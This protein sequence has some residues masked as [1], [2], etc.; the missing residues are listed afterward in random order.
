MNFLHDTLYIDRCELEYRISSVEVLHGSL[1]CAGR[2]EESWA[3]NRLS[4]VIRKRGIGLRRT[5]NLHITPNN[6][7]V[8]RVGSLLFLSQ[9]HGATVLKDYSRL[10][11][12]YQHIFQ[13]YIE[14]G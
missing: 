4:E 14:Y 5:P 7:P 1:R 13:A 2:A 11:H 10:A 8:P 6:Y 3:E 12:H 9:L